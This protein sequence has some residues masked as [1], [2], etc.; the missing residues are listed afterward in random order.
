MIE[1]GPKLYLFLSVMEG[2]LDH[3]YVLAI[4]GSRGWRGDEAWAWSGSNKQSGWVWTQEN[5]L[6]SNKEIFAVIL[7][8]V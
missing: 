5:M 6:E 8:I 4:P 7:D 1:P 3:L 2:R